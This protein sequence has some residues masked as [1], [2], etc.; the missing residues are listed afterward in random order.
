M[1]TETIKRMTSDFF[2]IQAENT[3]SIGIIGSI[4]LPK[5]NITYLYFFLPLLLSILCMI[6]CLPVYLCENLPIK[7]VIAQ[8]IIELIILEIAYLWI[9]SILFG[10]KFPLFGYVVAGF[11]I[12]FFDAATYLWNYTLEKRQAKRINQQLELSRLLR[13]K[14]H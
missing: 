7:L 11:S 8:R 13:N 1:S 14:K 3:L 12:L 9:M 4:F 5:E 6:P 2:M 10:E